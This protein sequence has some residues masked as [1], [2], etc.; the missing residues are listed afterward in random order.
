[1]LLALVACQNSTPP[2]A[3]STSRGAHDSRVIGQFG[4]L[5]V[6]AKD[7][8]AYV[9]KLPA[10]ERPRP[11][12]DL[13]AWY[14]NEVREILIQ[15]LLHDEALKAGIR[16][17]PE[18]AEKRLVAERQAVLSLCMRSR[19]SQLDPIDESALKAEYEDRKKQLSAPERRLVY[20]IF[21]RVGPGV[22][23]EQARAE[24]ESVRDR[25]L[26]GENFQR[27]A[28]QLSDS[29]TRHR[30]GSL[31]W[32]RPGDLPE[33]FEKV[34][35]SLPEG[36][37]G[38]PVVTREGVHLFYVDTI[39]PTRELS[40]EE[41]LPALR[42]RMQQ[43]RSEKTLKDLAGHVDASFD[44]PGQDALVKL[45]KAGD[46]SVVL[47][48]NKDYTLTLGELRGRL[49]QTLSREAKGKRKLPHALPV[50]ATWRFLEQMQLR[51]R[52]YDYCSAQGLAPQ[53]DV[54]AALDKWDSSVL[55]A[56][57]RQRRLLELARADE[58]SLKSFYNDNI[59]RFSSPPLWG[60]RRL[61]LS[62]G[63]DAP[64]KFARLEQAAAKGGIDLDALRT[65]LGGEIDDLGLR[66]Q[67]DLATVQ[68]KL[69]ARIAPLSVG[70][71][72][73]PYRTADKLEI[74][75]VTARK[76]A[77]P[78]PFAEAKERVA[79]AYVRQYTSELYDRL[80]KQLLPV[81]KLEIFPEALASLKTAGLPG[82]DVSAEELER[83]LESL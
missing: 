78:I 73:A 52:A 55:V 69:P 6:T 14:R 12:Q 64:Q 63:D 24:M 16:S 56:T 82:G 54:A 7:V 15:R 71:L 51:E 76:D 66:S 62:L 81:D 8:D 2:Q 17:E 39:L 41:A 18:F 50:E 33:G 57:Q 35:F 75:Q 27:L 11:G 26:R 36:V 80:A 53:K 32:L 48:R 1:M 38:E 5:T 40:F 47:L 42:T 49:R 3:V 23:V 74:L 21:R 25:V 70:Q 10:D 72:V 46:D 29:E 9:L 30:E 67:A 65:E 4:D 28:T 79:A 13:D 22:T 77:V 19:M 43:A 83:M 59:G 58:S 31:G 37:P 61:S 45:V 44:M 60:L 34:I 20:N 68:P